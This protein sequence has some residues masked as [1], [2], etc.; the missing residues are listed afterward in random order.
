MRASGEASLAVMRVVCCKVKPEC[1]EAYGALVRGMFNDMRNSPGF[2]GG[3]LIPPAT[4]DGEYQSVL[5]FANEE[6]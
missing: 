5:R 3:Q 1:G 4:S 6:D 2:L